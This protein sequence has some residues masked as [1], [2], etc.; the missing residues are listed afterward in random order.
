MDAETADFVKLLRHYGKLLGWELPSVMNKAADMIEALSR[1]AQ[2]GPTR[3]GGGASHRKYASRIR[4]LEG[5][6]H[7]GSNCP[8]R[9]KSV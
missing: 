2:P 4:W 8:K 5:L 9:Q 6:S 3:H 7:F 1:S